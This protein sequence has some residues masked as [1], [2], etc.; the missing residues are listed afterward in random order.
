MTILEA[1]AFGVPTMM[2]TGTIGAKDRLDQSARFDV[3]LRMD[4]DGDSCCQPLLAVR[5]L[6]SLL[7]TAAGRAKV[8]AAREPARTAAL[9]WGVEAFAVQLTTTLKSVVD[10]E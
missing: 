3:D 6:Q 10:R 8:D 1:A 4:Q 5:D 7:G 2:H 9:G